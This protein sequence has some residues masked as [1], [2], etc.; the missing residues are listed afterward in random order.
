MQV[1]GGT[2]GVFVGAALALRGVSVAVVERGVI[3]GRTQDWN[4]SRK[5]LAEIV[6]MG[7]LTAEE[8]EE[9]VGIEFNPNRCGFKGG[10]DIWVQGVLNLG[11]KPAV[12]IEKAKQRLL[13]NGG[14]VLERTP[15][16]AV[17][18]RPDSVQLALQT[19]EGAQTLTARLMLDCM[20]H[21]SPVVSQLRWG[22]KPDG[23]CLTVGSCSRGFTQNTTSDVIYTCEPISGNRQYFWEAF[24]AAS[25]PTDRTTY[26]F[27][28]LDAH[29]DRPSLEQVRTHH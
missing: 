29:P 3:A 27:T 23:V 18:V 14:R 15:L 4:I 2:L 9:A 24:P 19:P 11:V 25:H 26:M 12:L 21:N 16:D 17:V 13:D 28:Y 7:V 8:A 1:C 22:Q 20:G 10:E 5:E 6:A